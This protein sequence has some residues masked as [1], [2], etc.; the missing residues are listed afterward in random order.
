LR[1]RGG[2]EPIVPSRRLQIISDSFFIE[3]R[4]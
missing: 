1:Y 2:S 3:E 4:I